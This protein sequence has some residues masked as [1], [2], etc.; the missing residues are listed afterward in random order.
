[1]WM[2]PNKFSINMPY[3]STKNLKSFKNLGSEKSFESVTKIQFLIFQN[4][5]RVS[6]KCTFIS[7]N[8]ELGRPKP[9]K[10]AYMFV[11]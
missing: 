1:M 3:N 7:V 4:Q 11:K 9:K 8:K 2:A 10:Q 6:N 5:S